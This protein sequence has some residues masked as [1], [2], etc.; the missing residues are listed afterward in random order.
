MSAPGLLPP[1][2]P[3][4]T[5]EL[6]K[7]DSG[8]VPLGETLPPASYEDRPANCFSRLALVQ[9][10]TAL[11]GGLAPTLRR[12]TVEAGGVDPVDTYYSTVVAGKPSSPGIAQWSVPAGA[13][14]QAILDYKN[15]FPTYTTGQIKIN[16]GHLVWR[17]THQKADGQFRMLPQGLEVS[18]LAE[19]YH[20]SVDG[21]PGWMHGYKVEL[22]ALEGSEVNES[23]KTCWRFS[24]MWRKPGVPA[25]ACPQAIL[26]YKVELV[27]LEGSEVN[28]SRKTCWRFSLMW[29]KP[30]ETSLIS[31]AEAR[32]YRGPTQCCHA[33]WGSPCYAPYPRVVSVPT[34]ITPTRLS[35][36]GIGGAEKRK[37]KGMEKQTKAQRQL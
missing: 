20:G 29:R 7:Y 33:A 30:G 10:R 15:A 14:P 12:I 18:H 6:P 13:C 31:L 34:F 11:R 22:V 17:I 27:A 2:D 4:A 28:E 24:L 21:I 36:A 3:V 32:T 23:R 26:D 1:L 19:G 16:L 37:K 9:I 25:G 5:I 8:S 35:R